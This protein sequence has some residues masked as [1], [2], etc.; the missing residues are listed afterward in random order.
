VGLLTSILLGGELTESRSAL[1]TLGIQCV[2]FKIPAK[3]IIL[4][5]LPLTICVGCL[6]GFQRFLRSK[7]SFGRWFSKCVHALHRHYNGLSSLTNRSVSIA[8]F[9]MN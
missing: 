1:I 3:L 4:V 9:V 5:V 6:S 7:Q 8:L 2:E